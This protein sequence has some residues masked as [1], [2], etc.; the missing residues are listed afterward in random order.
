MDVPSEAKVYV[1]GLA[2]TSTGTH[3]R[4]ISRDLAAGYGY[5]YE[6]KIESV[7][8][9][10][11][12]E[13]VKTVEMR[14]GQT[15]SLAFNPAPAKS[16]ETTLTLN[17][18]EDAKVSLAGNPTNATGAVRVFST[19]NLASGKE[20]SN[21]KIVVTVERDGETLTQEQTV[22]LKAGEN[23]A[24]TIDFDAAKVASNK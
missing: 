1:N 21:Y 13:E 16:A 22:A 3:R 17:V 7:S 23:R 20:W 4:Y 14:A 18:P 15:A 6:V 19:T 8:N 24:V 9:G 10:K 2:T 12:V 5:T 11:V